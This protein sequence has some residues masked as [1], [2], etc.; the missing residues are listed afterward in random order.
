A[1]DY[2]REELTEARRQIASTV[3]KL[4]EV[5]KTLG[6]KPDPARYKAQITLALELVEGELNEKR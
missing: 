4:N 3:H 6:S 2:T 1:M 5:V